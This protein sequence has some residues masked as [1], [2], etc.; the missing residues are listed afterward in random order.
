MQQML[1]YYLS[2]LYFPPLGFKR[3]FWAAD[4]INSP[5]RA[6]LHRPHCAGRAAPCRRAP[7]PALATPKTGSCS[8]LVPHVRHFL[9]VGH[10]V[11]VAH[12]V[13]AQIAEEEPAF[14][15]GDCTDGGH[16]AAVQIIER[17]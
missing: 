14:V 11:N 3:L 2:M 13:A 12:V 6:C 8:S 4:K 9:L 5:P 10:E 7:L 15:L 1:Y 16:A 17:M